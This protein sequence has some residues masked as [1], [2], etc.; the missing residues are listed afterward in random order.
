M[1]PVTKPFVGP[2]P[3]LNE[4]PQTDDWGQIVRV[5]EPIAVI[6]TSVVP[7][8]S[9]VTP[10]PVSILSQ[11]I[12]PPRPN[13]TSLEIACNSVQ[14]LLVRAAAGACTLTNWTHRLY[15]DDVMWL[16]DPVWQGEVTAISVAADLTGTIQVTE[17][18]KT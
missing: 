13:R 2:A 1:P 15:M 14:P 18:W 3:I 11:V 8:N 9:L 17:Q 12:A 5:V 16:P 6:T 10:F 4:K 7:D